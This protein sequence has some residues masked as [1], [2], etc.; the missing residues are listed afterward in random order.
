MQGVI[1]LTILMAIF[2]FGEFLAEKTKAML[3]TALVVAIVML[4]GFWIGMPKDILDVSSVS[5]T[6]MIL[7]SFLIT[8]LGTTMNFNRLKKQWKTV[9]ISITGVVVGVGLIVVIGSLFIDRDMAVAGAPIFA[10]ANAAAL[11]MKDALEAKGLDSIFRFC[12]LV[13]VTQNFI[14]IPIASFLLKKEAENFIKDPLNIHKYNEEIKEEKLSKKSG[15]LK[16]P[17]SLNK[18]AVIFVKVGIVA[19][20]GH[21]LSQLTGGIIHPFVG[22]LLLG[23]LFTELGFLETDILQKT[24]SAT[25]ILFTTTVVIFGTLAQITPQ[26]ILSMIVPLIICLGV[27]VIGVIISGI[28]TGRILKVSPYLAIAM[29]LTCTF[30]FPTTMFMPVE[31]SKAVGRDEREKSAIENYL[32]TPMI[33]AGFVTVTIA[34][35]IVA[36]A[37]VQIL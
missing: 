28:I 33:T 2:A 8:S 4:V 9:I 6:G 18:P 36:S 5:T 12:I 24:N 37:V 31:V 23:I 3:S 34:S 21:L 22:G 27:G 1:A 16:L 13:L 19:I 29:G 26:E 25:F 10:G 14:G 35:V 32:S 20:L 17:S 30:G 7:V 15:P 11:I